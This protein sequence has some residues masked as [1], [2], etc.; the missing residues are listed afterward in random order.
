MAQ[1][2]GS[3]HG[4]ICSLDILIEAYQTAIEYDLI[5]R[6]LRLRDLGTDALTWSD[7]QAIVVW[8][9]PESALSRAYRGDDWP[10]GLQEM[11]TAAMVDGIRWLV[12]SKTSDAQHKRNQPKP[13]P[14]PGV[15]Q[16]E[17][18][19]DKPMSISEMNKFLGWEE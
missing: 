5:D 12:W 7:L 4:E 15:Q 17:R 6:G 11:L 14:R 2:L 16:A 10:W 9:G 19:G 1:A 18:Y 3:R 13:I 8:S